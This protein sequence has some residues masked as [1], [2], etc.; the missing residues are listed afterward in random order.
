MATDAI[1]KGLESPSMAVAYQFWEE[2]KKEFQSD[3]IIRQKDGL[4]KAYRATVEAIDTLLAF[5]GYSIPAGDRE[6][7]FVRRDK[8]VEIGDQDRQIRRLHERYSFF[9]EMLHGEGFYGPKNPK[10]YQ[11]IFDSVEDFLKKVQ[12]ILES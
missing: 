5:H 4:E 10:L 6:A 2:A 8:L 9:A 11:K 3:Y 12:E 1:P 7:H